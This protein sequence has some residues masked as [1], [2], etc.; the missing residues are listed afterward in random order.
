MKGYK[1]PVERL[2]RVFKKSRDTWKANA[3][4]KQKKLRALEIKVRDLKASRDYWK[5][6]A[7]EA[8]AQL[9]HLEVEPEAP[10]KKG[11]SINLKPPIL[12]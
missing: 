2:A 4:E 1:M 10:P 9:R 12:S 6:K 11:D 8:T 7:H 5:R 3:A